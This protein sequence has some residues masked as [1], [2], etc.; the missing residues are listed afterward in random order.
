MSSARVRVRPEG[1]DPKRNDSPQ[2]LNR[3][4]TPTSLRATIIN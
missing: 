2:I 3:N 1:M 4:L